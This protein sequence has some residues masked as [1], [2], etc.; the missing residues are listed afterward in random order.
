[1]EKTTF[2]AKV[3]KRE[4]ILTV[5]AREDMWWRSAYFRRRKIR[6]KCGEFI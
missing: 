1:M 5:G 3:A 4:V 6:G 2:S